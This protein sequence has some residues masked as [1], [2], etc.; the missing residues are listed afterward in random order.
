MHAPESFL[1]PELAET[2]ADLVFSCPLA[3]ASAYVAILLEHKSWAPLPVR[4]IHE[5]PIQAPE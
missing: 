4:A 3:D 5:S 2:Y 1:S